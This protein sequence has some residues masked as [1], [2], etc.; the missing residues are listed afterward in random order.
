MQ[1]C[2]C[3]SFFVHAQLRAFQALATIL[4]FADEEW[5]YDT[6][7]PDCVLADGSTNV[8]APAPC[9]PAKR[10]ATLVQHRS[11][12]RAWGRP[13]I[14]VGTHAGLIRCWLEVERLSTLHGRHETR[15]GRGLPSALDYGRSGLAVCSRRSWSSP[16]KL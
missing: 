11:I 15:R 4:N 10:L 7:L 6:A 13:S 16:C 9:R 14:R 2:W 5:A 1:L 3:W 8:Q 12:F